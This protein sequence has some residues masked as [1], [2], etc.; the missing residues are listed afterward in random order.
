MEADPPG[1]ESGQQPPDI[2][3]IVPEKRGKVN[4]SGNIGDILG[5]I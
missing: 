3:F 4:G 1:K 5:H 2:L